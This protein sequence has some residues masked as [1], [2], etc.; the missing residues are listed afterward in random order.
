[1]WTINFREALTS[2]QSIAWCGTVPVGTLTCEDCEFNPVGGDQEGRSE[3]RNEGGRRGEGRK[4]NGG[5]EK[6]G[7]K[8][9]K[10]NGIN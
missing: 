9:A 5:R 3:R 4:G 6:K 2:S 8:E 1:M 7:G 10:E